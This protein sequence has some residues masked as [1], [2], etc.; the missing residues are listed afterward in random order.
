MHWFTCKEL[1]LVNVMD[2]TNPLT[3]GTTYLEMVAGLSLTA[4]VTETESRF[5][6][7][8]VGLVCLKNRIVSKFITANECHALYLSKYFSHY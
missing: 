8:L 6:L 5:V 2:L 4:A 1:A 3:A 7:A